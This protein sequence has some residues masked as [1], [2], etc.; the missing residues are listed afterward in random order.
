MFLL[1]TLS[2]DLFTEWDRKW[3][4]SNHKK[5]RECCKPSKLYFNFFW[6][7]RFC[8][9]ILGLVKL[10]LGYFK[11]T[12]SIGCVAPLCCGCHYYTTSFNLAWTH[13]LHRFKPCLRCVRDSRCGGS[14]TTVPAGNKAKRLS[15]VNHTI[16][17]IHRHH[18]HQHHHHRFTPR[19]PQRF[20]M[21]SFVVIVNK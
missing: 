6:K 2:I 17:I 1:L 20:K 19:A 4:D 13:V 3:S 11:I 21:A 12:A 10:V 5:N 14:L 18:H 15:S 16:K 8:L 9:L 7:Q